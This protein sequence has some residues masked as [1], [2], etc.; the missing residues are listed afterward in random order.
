MDK[1][2]PIKILDR[3]W[4]EKLMAGEVFM[5]PLEEFGIHL[6]ESKRI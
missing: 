1:Y 4:A 2:V 3:Q 6:Y 5:L